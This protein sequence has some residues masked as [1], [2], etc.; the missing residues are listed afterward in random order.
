MCV[1]ERERSRISV[2]RMREMEQVESM[3]KSTR[4]NLY[5][6]EELAKITHKLL[7]TI[8]KRLTEVEEK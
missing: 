2:N 6:Q 1:C 8:F 3:L 5:E 7:E 4:C